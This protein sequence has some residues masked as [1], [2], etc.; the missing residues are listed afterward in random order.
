MILQKTCGCWRAARTFVGQFCSDACCAPREATSHPH[1]ATWSKDS[2]VNT[3][4]SFP[5]AIRSV[6]YNSINKPKVLQLA[7]N[8]L[9]E[10]RN[11]SVF[12]PWFC[13]KKVMTVMLTWTLDN[14]TISLKAACE[15]VTGMRFV[16]DSS[17]LNLN[18][19][20]VQI[21]S[22]LAEPNM[23]TLLPGLPW[24]LWFCLYWISW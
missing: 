14:S 8:V 21:S 7:L 18:G 16:V 11:P 5:P 20:L 17:I 4:L 22:D 12:V 19:M 1:Q 23:K 10:W 6:I 13:C 9:P 15:A 24:I 2:S 3:C